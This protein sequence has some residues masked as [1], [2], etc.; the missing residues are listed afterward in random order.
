MLCTSSIHFYS[1]DQDFWSQQLSQKNLAEF[2][3]FFLNFWGGPL[4]TMGIPIVPSYHKAFGM[5]D[6]GIFEAL[7]DS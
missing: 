4:M 7:N 3:N 1:V 6:L 5:G 2:F